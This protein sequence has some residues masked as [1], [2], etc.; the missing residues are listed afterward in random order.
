MRRALCI[1]LIL[2]CLL[3]TCPLSVYAAE[4]NNYTPQN[5]VVIVD[6]DGESFEHALPV[7]E[8][9]GE[10]YV[11]PQS[12]TEI[13]RYQLFEEETR[14]V[15]SLGLKSLWIDLTKQTLQVNLTN[16]P[17][18][19]TLLVNDT[20]YLPLSELLPWMNVQ[21][22]E[23]EGVLY[24]DSDP[25]S[26]WEVT[27]DF[28][29]KSR[30][31]LFDLSEQYGQTTTD[32]VGLCAISVF[33]CILDLDKIWKKIVPIE[34]SSTSLYDYEI[35]KECFREFALPDIGTEAEIQELVSS[36]SNVVSD[37]SQ[38][39]SSYYEAI[40]TQETYDKVAE[41][42]GEDI[43]EG[44]DKMPYDAELLTDTLK[45]AK[46]ALKHLKTSYLYTRIALGDTADYAQALRHMYMRDGITPPA[47]I[48][49][50]ASEAI[51]ALESQLGAIADAG[52]T[53]LADVG[54]KALEDVAEEAA[55]TFAGD[56]ILGSLGLYLDI[57]DAT[58]SLVWPV[59]DA[60]SD[61]R[62][63][64]VYQSIQ[65]DALNAYYEIPGLGSEVA[66]HDISNGRTCALIYLKTAKK[67]YKAQQKT[68]D[69]FGGEGV[70]D[71][72]IR[73]INKEI[74]QFELSALAE[75]RDAICDRTTEVSELKDLWTTVISVEHPQP[76]QYD[77]SY[78]GEWVNGYISGNIWDRTLT[79]NSIEGNH[80]NFDIEFYRIMGYENQTATI[81]SDG[82][83]TFIAADE[84]SSIAGSIELN[85]SITMHINESTFEYIEPET[86]VFARRNVQTDAITAL[87]TG[88]WYQ[89]CPDSDTCEEYTFFADNTYTLKTWEYAVSH[90]DRDEYIYDYSQGNYSDS[91]PQTGLYSIDAKGNL[92]ID[93]RTLTYNPSLDRFEGPIGWIVY[94]N[95]VDGYMVHYNSVPDALQIYLDH[96]EFQANWLIEN[97]ILDKAFAPGSMFVANTVSERH[98]AYSGTDYELYL[99]YDIPCILLPGENV[100][101]LNREIF[102]RLYPYVK[103]ERSALAQDTSIITSKISYNAWSNSELLSVQIFSENDFCDT[104][105]Y[106]VCTVSLDD[107]SILSSRD[108]AAQFDISDNYDD[109]IRQVMSGFARSMGNT[110]SDEMQKEAM[111]MV[112]SQWNVDNAV[113]F[114]G[115]NG[116]LMLSCQ[117]PYVL[118]GGDGD[119]NYCIP[120]NDYL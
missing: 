94:G 116:Q 6:K 46:T 97:D 114:I 50:A 59:N 99:A 62:K 79:I 105:E 81:N 34:D 47:G 78:L 40:Y 2:A 5:I 109:V 95:E 75:E 41:L 108:V 119:Y 63:M 117:V 10:L 31:Y 29:V 28:S 82:S 90:T 32:I 27:K 68:F 112:L 11:A 39:L 91:T 52:A 8:K 51:I 80:I 96:M 100:K 4:S 92:V 54:I 69:L 98:V 66:T 30:N 55:E 25:L 22:Y 61:I 73:D 118:A 19:G 14:F 3:S 120:V 35:Y 101:S 72:Q 104:P 58:L 93:D 77:T 115:E 86:I 60:Y 107:Y 7:I 106:I 13:T 45:L 70:L 49:L 84:Y 42:F 44:F 23:N 1:V 102:E 53:I 17:F 64:T 9:D 85:D 113:F 16:Q 48:E 21:C 57:I 65:Y 18:S 89:F 26:Y 67:C 71:Y 24:I 37:S 111:N 103:E 15:Y 33:D 76:P 83:I 74:L 38:F 12:L 87:T 56:T 36:L 43:A 20:H 110:E 88:V